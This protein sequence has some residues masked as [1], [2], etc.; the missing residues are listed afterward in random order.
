MPNFTG[1]ST[2]PCDVSNVFSTFRGLT[3]T[4]YAFA[5]TYN[6]NNQSIKIVN[7]YVKFSNVFP[8]G[9]YNNATSYGSNQNFAYTFAY[10]T[11]GYVT[12]EAIK[13]LVDNTTTNNYKYY[14]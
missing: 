7:Q 4:A 9:V 3:N 10:Y 14:G 6:E 2:S 12:H 1:T 5:A 11:S 8:T 13:T